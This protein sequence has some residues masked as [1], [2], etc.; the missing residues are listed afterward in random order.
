MTNAEIKALCLANIV[1][2]YEALL[3]VQDLRIASLQMELE[4]AKSQ[5]EGKGGDE[6]PVAVDLAG[7]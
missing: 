3:R 5:V 6:I 1:A 2:A 4:E 7:E